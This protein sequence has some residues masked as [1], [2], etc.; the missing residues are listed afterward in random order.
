M[1][2][3]RLT[4]QLIENQSPRT[5]ILAAVFFLLGVTA[6]QVSAACSLEKDDRHWIDNSLSTWKKIR[7]EQF[8]LEP[9]PT[10]WLLLFDRRCV[11]HINPEPALVETIEQPRSLKLSHEK[12]TFLAVE[13]AGSVQLPEN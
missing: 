12:V 1:R 8:N 2:A 13:H 11:F 10:P 6:V 4:K 7:S 3:L 5:S 9:A